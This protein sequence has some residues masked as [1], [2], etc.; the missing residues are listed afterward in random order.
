MA[1]S[2]AGAI[3]DE[4]AALLA[5]LTLAQTP[6]GLLSL[7]QAVGYGASLAGQSPLQAA[8]GD[9]AA[10]VGQLETLDDATLASWDGVAKALQVASDI[11]AAVRAVEQAVADPN[12]A[13][14]AAGLG[15][16][17]ASRLVGLYLR[18][19][20]P[21]L[22]RA[23]AMLTLIDP[24][25]LAVPSALTVNQGVIVREPTRDDAF[26]FE[27]V[28]ALLN[29]PWGTLRDAYFPNRLASAPDAHAAAARFFPLVD[30]LVREL[31]LPTSQDFRSLDPPPDDATT[32]EMEDHFG[33]ISQASD[34][35]VDP[36]PPPDDAAFLL[37]NMPRQIIQ[38]A[39]VG[40][41]AQ[42]GIG[43]VISSADQAGAVAGVTANVVGVASWS[44]TRG[45]WNLQA[46]TTGQVP[47]FMFGPGGL[48]LPSSSSPGAGATGSASLAKGQ[49]S[50]PA[51]Q[52]GD[53]NGSRIE[54]GDLRA[55]LDFVLSPSRQAIGF[56]AKA[57]QARLVVAPQGDGLLSQVL[58]SGGASLVCDL[59]LT[60]W[61]DGGVDVGIS[62][63]GLPPSGVMPVGKS[64]GPLVIQSISRD[65]RT[66]DTD[67]GSGLTLGIGVNLAF[68]FGP[69]TASLTGPSV[70][71]DALWSLKDPN[72]PKNL[73]FLHLDGLGLRAPTGVGLAIDAT[74]VVTGGGAL[75]IDTA[76]HLYAGELELSLQGITVKAFGLISTVAPD[77]SPEFSLLVMITAEG[78][79]PIQLGLGFNLQSI[80]GLIAINRTFD[81]DVLRQDLSTNTLATLLFPQD[82]I[83]NAAAIIQSL[84]AAFP[85]KGGSYLIGLLARICWPTPTLVQMD[86]ALVLQ[87]GSQT[88]LLVL[89][90]ISS[91]LP[92]RDNDL[93]RLNLDAMG[94]LDFDQ[95]TVVI[96]SGK[97]THPAP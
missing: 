53:A 28:E 35:P 55:Q 19:Q 38:V 23:A 80:G 5:P 4:L 83:A 81:Q 97:L 2:L 26:H 64:L 47:V 68:N 22:H 74:G 95:G 36:T 75:T 7:L 79:E 3:R 73:G 82:P 86:L 77:G 88:R 17:I 54:V 52:L 51:F 11:F 39:N 71:V 14:E 93:V 45:G 37:S 56:T 63:Q 72:Q 18:N 69:L 9:V 33:D 60:F 6:Q 34:A 21:R 62:V 43:L 87:V 16:A 27:R 44:E 32:C 57:E 20:H 49:G 92:S 29:D 59:S 96:G 8:I 30:M 94:V 78:F 48:R 31:G 24:A 89:G 50:Q 13:S 67:V 12:L 61:S 46:T 15:E 76:R 66:V 91:L 65:F 40:G 41:S 10:L 42:L 1:S 90:R 70:A 25:E 84:S 58:P 85:V